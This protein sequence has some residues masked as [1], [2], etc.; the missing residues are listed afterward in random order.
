MADQV[1]EFFGIVPQNLEHFSLLSQIVQ[2]EAMK[3]FI[4]NF[5]AAKWEKTGLIWWNLV[6]GW[7]EL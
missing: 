4:E 5:R 7:A 3:H 6:E 1:Q 2:A